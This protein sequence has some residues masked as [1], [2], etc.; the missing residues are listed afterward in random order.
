MNIK[1]KR[2]RYG[3]FST[4][5]ILFAV[6]LFVFVNLVADEFNRSFDLTP[7]G[8]FSLS[9]RSHD[10]LETL[11]TDVTIT[12]V[13]QLASDAPWAHFV[14][15]LL[16]EYDGASRHITVQVRDP[17]ISPALIHQFAD[18]AGIEGGIPNGSVVV[19]SGNKTRVVTPSDM[20]I[21][22]RDMLGFPISIRSLSFE[23]TITRAIH[24]VTLGDPP[25]IYYVTGSGEHDLQPML[26]LFLESENFVVRE[27]NLVTGEVP[28]TADILLIPMPGR[29]WTEVKGQRILDYLANEGRA[30]IAADITLEPM[31]VFDGVLA[32]Y[33]VA[34]LNYFVVEGNA[35][36]FLPPSPN[37]IF[38]NRLPHEI[39]ENLV[40]RNMANLLIGAVPIETLDLRRG[41]TNI[42]PLWVTSRE[43]FARVDAEITTATKVPGDIDGPFDLA[44]AITDTRFID[45]T[46]TTQIVVVGNMM[47]LNE[48]IIGVAGIGNYQFILDAMH[49]LH[50]EPPSIFIPGRLPPGQGAQLMLTQRNANV[51]TG[52]AVGALPLLCI[53]IGIVVWLRRRH[54]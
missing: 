32:S 30:F 9:D 41:S 33:G 54:N 23:A 21:F 39:N 27:V 26:R 25:V 4:A 22:E 38:P 10:F 35:N 36:N 5:M 52:I 34:T 12:H 53:V 6:I 13:M 8:I 19:Q 28:E 31:P 48:G 29:D 49:W 18:A 51:M 15:P 44:V 37:T 43:A 14:S 11:D 42:E 45:S 1:E 16:E 50:G 40:G 47:V 24:Y 17:A 46:L 7:D 3:T 2:F 20:V